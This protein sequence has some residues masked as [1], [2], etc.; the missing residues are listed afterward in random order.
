MPSHVRPDCRHYKGLKPCSF[1]E[2][3]QGCPDFAPLGSR[4]LIIKL[5]A[6]GDVLRTTPLLRGLRNEAPDAEVIWLTSPEAAELL[7]NNPFIGQVWLTGAEALVR[8]QVERFER[9]ICLDKEPEAIACAALAAAPRKFGFGMNEL[10]RLIVFNEAAQENLRL[11]VSDEL[12]FRRNTKTY[13]EIMFETAE[14]AFGREYDYVFEVPKADEA[15]ARAFMAERLK[16]PAKL[17]I[18]FNLGGGNVF[19]HKTWKEAHFLKLRRLIEAKWGAQAA[20]AA[21]GGPAEEAALT[22]VVAAQGPPIIHTGSNNS[23][24]RF[25]ALIKQCHVVVTGDSLA[26]HLALAVGTRCLVL[27]GST[28]PREIELYGR[29]KM[30]ASD[31]DCAPCYG[32]ECLREPDC[33]AL[34]TPEMVMARLESLVKR[35]GLI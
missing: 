34:F 23:L 20:V 9:V 19:A 10:G 2:D 35:A 29:G 11:G 26:M 22:R 1:G 24:A 12:K 21:L 17:V 27:I 18:G 16:P 14:V 7:K 8:L 6:L 33:M 32:R 15:W 3:C 5:G 30:L 28:T 13:Q 25:A 4:I 31:L